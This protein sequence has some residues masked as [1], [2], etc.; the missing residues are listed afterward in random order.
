MIS[1]DTGPAHAAAAMDC[2]LVVMFGEQDQR[3]WRPRSRHAEVI[4]VGGAA[5]SASRMLDISVDEVLSAW[6]RLTKR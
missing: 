4:A 2:P 6:N 5:G 3:V 1:V